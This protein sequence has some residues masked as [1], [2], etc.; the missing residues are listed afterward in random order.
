MSD[1]DEYQYES[2]DDMIEYVFFQFDSHKQ[3]LLHLFMC[4]DMGRMSQE[5]WIWK[6]KMMI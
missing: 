4:S 2:D 1:S 3:V 6:M 5:A